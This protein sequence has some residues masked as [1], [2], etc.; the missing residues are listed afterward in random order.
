[1]SEGESPAER[2]ANHVLLTRFNLPSAGVQELIRAKDGWLRERVSLFERFTVP[3][4]VGQ[5][6]R[7]FT[8]LIYFD[9]ASPQ[10]LRQMIAKY[11]HD[12]TFVPV[13]R[14][15]V[16]TEQMISDIRTIIG[17]PADDLLTTNLDN[18]D[19]IATD[20]IARLQGG[21][22]AEFQS[23]IYVRNGLIRTGGRL[24]T[25]RYP[26][27][28][29]N[30]VRT[31]WATPTATCWSEWHTDFDKLMPAIEIGGDAGW[32]QVVHGSNV[33]NRV[34]GRLASPGPF[35]RLFPSALDGLPEPSARE[36]NLDRFVVSPAR[37]SRE[38]VR[39]AGKHLILTLFGR[40]ALDRI[41]VILQPRNG[42]GEAG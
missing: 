40:D 31:P 11:E 6:N 8:W 41:K 16:S 28:A 14:E 42:S 22:V 2:T 21:S 15:S 9:P 20:F 32:M 5:T 29:F 35:R 34:R 13:F 24:Y 25:H 33:S 37:T 7:H 4:V 3:S 1:M 23:A 10:W 30:S 26:R 19:V 17:T 18:D 12:G 27:N 36:L 39:S 38:R